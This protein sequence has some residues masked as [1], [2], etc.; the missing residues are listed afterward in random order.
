MAGTNGRLP[1]DIVYLSASDKSRQP[2]PLKKKVFK[3]DAKGLASPEI[4][5]I[6]DSLSPMVSWAPTP[7]ASK[8]S[9][10][11]TVRALV[12]YGDRFQGPERCEGPRF[13]RL[14]WNCTLD[15]IHSKG[16][17]WHMEPRLHGTPMVTGAPDLGAS[18]VT[19]AL[20]ISGT[21]KPRVSTGYWGPRLE[22][23]P[24]CWGRR[25]QGALIVSQASTP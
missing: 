23:P 8:L 5:K 17:P 2:L 3:V 19:R 12:V 22:G 21:A 6:L 1:Q 15:P 18:A 7:R 4:P 16:P 14:P 13:Q 10:T 24:C 20:M 11:S 9:G 25:L